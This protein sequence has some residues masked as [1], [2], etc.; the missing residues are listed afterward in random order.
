MTALSGHITSNHAKETTL[1]K[2]LACAEKEITPYI[3]THE[4]TNRWQCEKS[5][6]D[7]MTKRAD[8]KRLYLG[9]GKNGIVRFLRNEV[10]AYEK[11][12]MV[13]LFPGY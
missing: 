13:C 4:L 1:H 10:E 7:R 8:M 2:K 5:S 11:S 6:V 9:A 3:F 12:R